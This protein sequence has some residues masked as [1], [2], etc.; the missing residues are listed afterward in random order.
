VSKLSLFLDV[1]NNSSFSFENLYFFF[2]ERGGYY[3]ELKGLSNMIFFDC[4]SDIH[5][6]LYFYSFRDQS[7]VFLPYTVLNTHESVNNNINSYTI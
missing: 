2:Y 6:F 1:S 4:D 7:V 5:S 3:H